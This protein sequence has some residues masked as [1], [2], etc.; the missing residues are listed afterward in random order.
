[1]SRTDTARE[2]RRP[3]YLYVDEF[4]TMATRFFVSLLS[5]GR[6]FGISLVLANQFMGQ[7]HDDAIR[8]SIFGNVG[9]IVGFRTGHDDAVRLA[10]EFYPGPTPKDFVSL[11]NWRAYTRAVVRGQRVPAFVLETIPLAPVRDE[12]ASA[13]AR[14]FSRVTYSARRP[15]APPGVAAG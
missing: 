9:T 15:A 12:L 2:R 10:H 13:R 11:P 6:K 8:E 3:F 1:M 7:I 4:G 5:E 14:A